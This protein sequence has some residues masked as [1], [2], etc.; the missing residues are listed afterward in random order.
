MIRGHG[1]C[2]LIAENNPDEEISGDEEVSDEEVDPSTLP[3]VLFV[4]TTDE[5]Y[6]NIAHFLT[7][8][9]CSNHLTLKEKRT[10]KLKSAS[11]VL[12]DNSL[13]KCAMDGTFL[14]CVDKEQQQKL[15]KYYHDLACGG[16]FSVLVTTHKI[17]RVKYY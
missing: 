9:E 12:W 17:L 5:W 4:S 3:M 2:Q 10:V 16:H 6:S 7:Y 11:F 13:Y 1:L 14:R 15:L 8:R